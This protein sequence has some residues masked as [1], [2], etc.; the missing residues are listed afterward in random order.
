[1][2][3]KCEVDNDIVKK[4][5]ELVEK[6]YKDEE[7]LNIIRDSK[8]NMTELR[9]PHLDLEKMQGEFFVKGYRPFNIFTKAI[10]YFEGRTC[11]IN[12]RKMNMSLE[13][14]TETIFHEICGHGSGY[15][16]K[17]NY[18]TSFNLQTFPYL[19]SKLF[20]EYLKNKMIL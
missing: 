1:M 18:V 20:V 11:H 14:R 3:I 16:H 9:W 2:I 8:F 5:C 10:G 7:F 15:Q 6:H 12:T 17:G 13:D 19:G 4:A